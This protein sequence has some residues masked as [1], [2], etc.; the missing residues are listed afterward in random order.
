MFFMSDVISSISNWIM[1]LVF[2]CNG[3]NFIHHSADGVGVNRC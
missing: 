1:S 2:Q 3:S